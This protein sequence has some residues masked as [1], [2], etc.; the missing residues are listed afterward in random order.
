M[1]CVFS[2]LCVLTLVIALVPLCSAAGTITATNPSDAAALVYVSGYEMDPGVFY[3]YESGTITVHVTNAANASVVVAEPDLIEP[4]I[5]V[6]NTDVFNTKTSIGPGATVSYT[7]VVSVDATDGNYY[8]LFTLAPVAYSNPVH[9][10]LTVKVDSADARATISQKPDLFSISKK[11]SVN[12]TIVNPR[13]DD[14]INAFVVASSPGAEIFPEER[15]IGTIPANSKA[16]TTFQITPDAQTDVFFNVTFDNGDNHRQTSVVLPLNIGE[17]KTGAEIVV[18]NIESSSSGMTQ[19]LKGDV[20]NN[21]LV[22]AKSVL[23]TVGS[24][25]TPVDPNPVYAIG[26]LEPDDFSSFEV[27]YTTT[28]NGAIPVI[29]EYKDAEGNTFTNKFSISANTNSALPGAAAANGA[30]ASASSQR[31]GM[32]GSF[33]S[34]ASQI[35]VTEIVIALIAIIALIVAWRKGLLKRL[36]NRFRKDPLPE[37]NDDEQED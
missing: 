24:P 13:D 22:D 5:K 12:I 36:A 25:A 3:P 14:L 27:T 20:T 2:I 31:R 1:K 37:N 29:V 18:N 15:Y 7:F 4:H 21:G 35:P 23:V 10:T 30:P 8:P 11:S 16:E 26:N 32:F 33:G 9:S 28:G 34:G 19:T 6:K 17:D